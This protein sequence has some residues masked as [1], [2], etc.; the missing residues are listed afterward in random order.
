MKDEAENH[1]QYEVEHELEGD[2][3]A[4]DELLTEKA[5]VLRK[6]R[7][8]LVAEHSDRDSPVDRLRGERYGDRRHL[9]ERD[10]ESVE[11]PGQ[12][13]HRK[14][15]DDQRRNRSSAGCGIPH[16]IGAEGD[17]RSD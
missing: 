10:H 4:F 9:E 2:R 3:G 5:E 6:G 14:G 13:T 11:E 16:G 8:S 7:S 17:D 15:D 1:H 12:G